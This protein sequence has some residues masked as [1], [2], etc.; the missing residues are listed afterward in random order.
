MSIAAKSKGPTPRR[1][2]ERQARRR[3]GW[4]VAPK[5]VGTAWGPQRW[6]LARTCSNSSSLGGN[7][8]LSELRRSSGRAAVM[9]D[10]TSRCPNRTRCH[11]RS[12]EIF[13]LG[14]GGRMTHVIRQNAKI[15]QVLYTER[16]VRFTRACAR[17][18]VSALRACP[19]CPEG[20]P[21]LPVAGD[22]KRQPE[23][24]L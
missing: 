16:S 14:R 10:P 17:G 4:M 13:R 2:P 9:P 24:G 8:S 21:I 19:P 12:G 23:D 11:G 7:T 1:S 18:P 20:L 22:E 6:L 15:L 3:S 5:M